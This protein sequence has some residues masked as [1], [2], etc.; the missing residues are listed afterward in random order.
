MCQACEGRWREEGDKVDCVDHREDLYSK[1][2]GSIIPVFHLAH[3][4]LLFSIT[5]IGSFVYTQCFAVFPPILATLRGPHYF[6]R[7]DCWRWHGLVIY[8]ALGPGCQEELASVFSNFKVLFPWS[9]DPANSPWFY[10]VTNQIC[11]KNDS[12]CDAIYIS[13]V[14][15][16]AE[17]FPDPYRLCFL[18]DVSG[19]IV[20][21][22]F[23][24]DI[25]H[26]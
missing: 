13:S 25:C 21:S 4:Y 17:H 20:S 19:H 5:E 15:K 18:R 26:R 8:Q 3:V 7:T 11:E 24:R 9:C 23:S 10:I 1:G 14:S 12:L 6:L 22:I 2:N 16:E